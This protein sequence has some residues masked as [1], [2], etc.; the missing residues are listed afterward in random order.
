M[1]LHAHALAP[2]P[3]RHVLTFFLSFPVRNVLFPPDRNV[4]F[5]LCKED[6]C[7]STAARTSPLPFANETVTF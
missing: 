3:R 2:K 4:L 7:L 1:S 5:A 6:A